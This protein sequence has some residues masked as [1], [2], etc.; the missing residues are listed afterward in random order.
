MHFPFRTPFEGGSTFL[1]SSAVRERIRSREVHVSIAMTW[2]R[3]S[4]IRRSFP[5]IRDDRQA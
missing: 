5:L 1:F 2:N 3:H 4:S